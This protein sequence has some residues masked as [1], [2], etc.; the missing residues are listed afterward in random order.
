MDFS[1]YKG[2][3]KG[4]WVQKERTKERKLEPFLILKSVTY[5]ARTCFCRRVFAGGGKK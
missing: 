1:S 3:T 4:I 2:N 5:G